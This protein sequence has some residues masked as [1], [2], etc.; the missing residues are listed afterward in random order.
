MST[1]SREVERA[2]LDLAWRQWIALGVSAWGVK[3]RPAAPEGVA[4]DPEALVLM[5]AS[6]A[7]LDARLRDEATDWCVSYGQTLSKVRLKRQ[8]RLGIGDP[9]AFF[10]FAA[11]VN[12]HAHLGWP[13]HGASPRRFKP[14]GRL[15]LVARGSSAAL[16]IRARLIF[17]VSARAELLVLLVAEQQRTWSASE[18]A[19]RVHY[20]RRNVVEAL[21]ALTRTEL[22]RDT[23]AP[24]GRRYGLG[25]PMA[26]HAILGA[27]PE[28]VPDW[29]RAFR[30]CWIGMETLRRFEDALPSVRSVEATKA[31]EQ[32][33][34]ELMHSS[35][36]VPVPAPKGGDAWPRFGPW[37]LRL[38]EALE[39]P[40]RGVSAPRRRPGI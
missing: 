7:P 22:V 30:A 15:L 13:D 37:V 6:L 24:G 35:F 39:E 21:E 17:G 9:A 1:S 20:G 40:P 16:R 33:E 23:S 38:I 25:D 28:H 12:K 4:V 8:V 2:M 31:A 32:M 5:T 18:L 19:E 14:T 3:P 34:A 10:A 29:A 11:T 27:P 36:A 26:L